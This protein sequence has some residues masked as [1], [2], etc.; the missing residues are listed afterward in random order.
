M[1]EPVGTMFSSSEKHT[2]KKGMQSYFEPGTM[3]T[4]FSVLVLNA[5]YAAS[6][7]L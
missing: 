1:V 5:V 6:G 3:A 7:C 2:N 4:R